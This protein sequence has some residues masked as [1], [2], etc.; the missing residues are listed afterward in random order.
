MEASIP[1][2][3]VVAEEGAP[4]PARASITVEVPRLDI[5]FGN[6]PA[7][8]AELAKIRSHRS[9][10][11]DQDTAKA[12]GLAAGAVVIAG[13]GSEEQAYT[14]A[15][16]A[17]LQA[18]AQETEATEVASVAAASAVE[19]R[20]G[21]MEEAR[22]AAREAEQNV[23]QSWRSLKDMKK[24]PKKS[25][26]IL[27]SES[28]R[29][30]IRSPSSEGPEVQVATKARPFNVPRL[31]LISDESM[32]RTIETLS[33]HGPPSPGTS[34]SSGDSSRSRGLS[35]DRGL[36][37]DARKGR[38]SSRRPSARVNPMASHDEIATEDLEYSQEAPSLDPEEDS[39]KKRGL[40][41]ATKS[42]MTTAK[43]KAAYEAAA[44]VSKGATPSEAAQ[45]AVM[46]IEDEGGSEEDMQVA[47]AAAAAA[48]VVSTGG[49]A[50]EAAREAAE[51][52]VDAGASEAKAS[53]VAVE[54]TEEII[55]QVEVEKTGGSTESESRKNMPREQEKEEKS[56]EKT[57]TTAIDSARSNLSTSSKGV[58]DE[59]LRDVFTSMDKTGSGSI[60]RK[61]VMIALRRSAVVRTRL[62]LPEKLTPG[63]DECDEFDRVYS[64]I[65]NK[66]SGE[67]T[68]REFQ[69]HFGESG[70]E[71]SELRGTMDAAV[72]VTPS[73][74]SIKKNT[75][76]NEQK[77]V[78]ESTSGSD[79]PCSE[80]DSI[81][82]E[83]RAVR[84]L[85][86]KSSL[87]DST[88]V[89]IETRTK[90][91]VKERS[92]SVI[93]PRP[94][95]ARLSQKTAEMAQKTAEDAAAAVKEAEEAR[96]AKVLASRPRALSPPG[97]RKLNDDGTKKPRDKPK[98]RSPDVQNDDPFPAWKE[99]RME[100]K[101]T[102]ANVTFEK[103]D[104]NQDGVID[105][106]EFT[107]AYLSGE[108]LGDDL[109]PR[110]QKIVN[111]LDELRLLEEQEKEL[112]MELEAAEKHLESRQKTARDVEENQDIG[113]KDDKAS[114]QVAAD[115][116]NTLDQ[117]SA[118]TPNLSEREFPDQGNISENLNSAEGKNFQVQRRRL[119]SSTTPPAP[120]GRRPS[121]VAQLSARST[122]SQTSGVEAEARQSQ[123]GNEGA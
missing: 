16:H 112:A 56:Q 88:Q 4:P 84:D 33:P 27:T 44:L 36:S 80:K 81:A 18:G 26:P 110:R 104:V 83:A 116:R 52:A 109:T 53:S 42:R 58:K 54:A 9:G 61:E 89:E 21:S 11:S 94:W 19:A 69:A 22:S 123:T 95:E 77:K 47:A 17:A 120:I 62:G 25:T 43:E 28:P 49:T 57:A 35:S 99:A 100:A 91:K 98:P 118:A 97:P 15:A 90:E 30:Y 60:S 93:P 113:G 68:W 55:A 37:M 71:R 2:A 5:E 24:S 48:A 122:A 23:K 87:A 70:I 50:A 8:A 75:P 101:E 14:E 115:V 117:E 111:G 34:Y 103:V 107:N 74:S 79:N 86:E 29:D 76:I 12:A 46:I 121:R 65:E 96:T 108:L 105:R 32:V 72:D 6:A 119:I 82:A 38:V 31:N 3:G 67:V 39:M 20:G 102:E 64:G 41:G 59:T 106:T 51:A 40:W 66:P 92:S 13:G 73:S 63:S 7:E 1:E 114:V 10:A 85:L 78:T 45:I